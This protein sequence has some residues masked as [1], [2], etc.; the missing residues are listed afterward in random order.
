M[1]MP[2]IRIW[3]AVGCFCLNREYL[4]ASDVINAVWIYKIGSKFMK[5]EE[6]RNLAGNIKT[7]YRVEERALY[8][9]DIGDLPLVMTN[10]LFKTLPDFVV[11]PK[12][13]EE[14]RTVVKIACEH[15][16]PVVLRGAA[17]WGLGGGI[18]ANAGM[19]VD[20]SPLRSIVSID[21]AGKTVKVEAGARWSEIDIFA[22]KEGLCLEAYPSSKFSTVGGWIA[23][24]GYVINSYKYGH[25]SE[26]IVSMTVVTGNGDIRQLSPS[27]KDFHCFVS[28]EGTFGIISEVTLRLR[29]I[30]E[31]SY[32]HLFYFPDDGAAFTFVQRFATKNDKQQY[33]PDFI[34]FLDENHLGDLNDILRTDIFKKSAAVLFEFGSKAEEAQFLA[35]MANEKGIEE[36][37]GYAASYLWN[38]RLFGMKT[39]RLGP[40][41][42]ASEI[43]I[44]IE[45][46]ADFIKK[47]KK[48]GVFWGVSVCID[49][50]IL[51]DKNALIMATF[52]CD[53]RRLKY[54]TNLPLVAMLT[55]IA[56]GLGGR[57]Y[58]LGIW[59]AA[60]V[61]SIYSKTRLQELKSCKARLDPGYV[62]NQGKPFSLSSGWLSSLFFHPAFFL[63]AVSLLLFMSPVIGRVVT[64]L[65]GKEKKAGNLDYELSL[66]ACAKC[67]NCITVC[68]AYLITHDESLTA[69]GK[70]ALA[71]KFLDDEHSVTKEEAQRAFL[72]MHCRACEEVCE[73]NLELMKLWDALE[74]KLECQFGRP[75]IQIADFLKK[76]EDS[77]EYWAMVESN[78]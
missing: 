25:V 9:R 12:N 47:A 21:T 5:T 28:T 53:S 39:K 68:P 40:T 42:L 8:S 69:K 6:F 31:G 30:P 2:Y 66:H 7:L 74:I 27:D 46:S 23:T 36:A 3:I 72:C 54:Y 51:D 35:Y 67:G 56:A 78:K 65:L 70:I 41:L 13:T 17:S 73:T 45:S 34:R 64:I 62:L 63:P 32:P 50:F 58:G 26:Q 48:V 71:K 24:G 14:I 60:F 76:V 20:I 43:I 4:S 55:K 61:H 11:Q 75:D 22:R 19:V 1:E 37:P 10:V 33:K 52:L 16:I 38:E 77:Q 15:K 44:P 57:P 18:P 29:D 59:N 49:S